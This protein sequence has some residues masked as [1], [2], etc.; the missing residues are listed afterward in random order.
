MFVCMH[1]RVT[2]ALWCLVARRLYDF[3]TA[4]LTRY[5]HIINVSMYV[6]LSGDASCCCSFCCACIIVVTEL[7]TAN[8]VASSVKTLRLRMGSWHALTYICLY[9]FVCVCLHAQ[10]YIALTPIIAMYT[11]TLNAFAT[12]HVCW[13]TSASMGQRQI[14]GNSLATFGAIKLMCLKQ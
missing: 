10:E 7:V 3:L 14:V 12:L 8:C 13:H 4:P 11:C 9:V 2:L 6:C 5:H 1:N